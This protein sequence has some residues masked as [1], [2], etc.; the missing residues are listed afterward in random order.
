MTSANTSRVKVHFT[1]QGTRTTVDVSANEFSIGRSSECDVRI[2]L[3]EISRK[4]LKVEV[5]GTKLIITDLSSRN[6]VYIGGQRVTPNQ[7]VEFP[8]D[9]EV[10]IG[11]SVILGLEVVE[12]RGTETSASLSSSRKGLT[13]AGFAN[14]TH[15]GVS[16]HVRT[17]NLPVS[18]IEL[19]PMAASDTVPAVPVAEDALE[20]FEARKSFPALPQAPVSPLA[21]AGDF[22]RASTP[23]ESS[24]IVVLP[25]PP[26]TPSATL[27]QDLAALKKQKND[28]QGELDALHLQCTEAK[29]EIERVSKLHKSFVSLKEKAALSLKEVQGE[30]ES[31]HAR[32][33]ALQS[34]HGNREKALKA[35]LESVQATLR[36]DIEKLE[37]QLQERVRSKEQVEREWLAFLEKKQSADDEFVASERR[38]EASRSE[39]NLVSQKLQKVGADMEDS[40]AKAHDAESRA[41][42][43]EHR[44]SDAE[45]KLGDLDVQRAKVIDETRA[46]EKK[47]VQLLESQRESLEA[48]EAASVRLSALKTEIAETEV[49]FEAVR[50]ETVVKDRKRLAEI[51][52]NE[53]EHKVR[54]LKIMVESEEV[55]S[56]KAILERELKSVEMAKVDAYNHM[57]T[58]KAERAAAERATREVEHRRKELEK[59]CFE[60]ESSIRAISNEMSELLT[61]RELEIEAVNKASADRDTLQKLVANQRVLAQQESENNRAEAQRA[62]AEFRAEAEQEIAIQRE[63]FRVEHENA[64]KALDAELDALRARTLADLET[65]SSARQNE[66]E[67]EVISRTKKLELELAE[68]KFKET[69]AIKEMRNTEERVLK[70]K[71]KQEIKALLNVLEDQVRLKVP[72]MHRMSEDATE[73]KSF[74]ENL[75]S[76][77]EAILSADEKSAKAVN[78]QTFTPFN[79]QVAQ[80]ERDSW[81]RL[82]IKVS[83]MVA[84][85][86][87][88]IFTPIVDKTQKAVSSFARWQKN[89]SE[90]A[91]KRMREARLNRPKFDPPQD[92]VYRASYTDNIVYAEGYAILKTD[93]QIAKEWTLALTDLFMNRLNVG[94]RI[95]P[96]FIAAETLMV[97]EL[98]RVR[99]GILPETEIQGVQRMRDVEKATVDR[100]IGF[101]KTEENYKQF[102]SFESTFYLK[103]ILQTRSPASS[104]SE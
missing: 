90:T 49:R 3:D 14:N 67:R 40:V 11:V 29:L 32:L 9:K 22:S 64:R 45:A 28:V 36:F 4:H 61:R 50:Q 62:A 12:S 41:V 43:S 19:L 51:E 5:Q 100:L 17:M 102:R 91:V 87:I 25:Q 6:G 56:K 82:G 24:R 1:V 104:E 39:L 85:L 93:D 97:K 16:A 46:L 77:A 38:L 33:T 70:A 101:L 99:E 48:C 86:V 31:A 21:S 75:Q 27:Q 18:E 60:I 63:S 73:L 53:A 72:S 2:N 84:I 30:V 79:P 58:S 81:K 76:A 8:T 80:N 37:K 74:I 94:D 34:E 47:N 55:L 7:G 65:V 78:S 68:L 69:E 66:V 88:L 20:M 10:Q 23:H 52:A 98:I 35:E 83:A 92:Q 103:F 13:N 59:E 42:E 71:R 95:V 26:Q 96:D 15:T 89:D 57:E 44:V 54:M